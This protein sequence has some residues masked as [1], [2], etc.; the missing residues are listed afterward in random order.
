MLFVELIK[1]C[2]RK[3]HVD[4]QFLDFKGLYSWTV[5]LVNTTPFFFSHQL[6]FCEIWTPQLIFQRLILIYLRGRLGEK[7][8]MC[9]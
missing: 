6:H 2:C 4:R 8:Q 5:L 7:K 1:E 3:K 9:V